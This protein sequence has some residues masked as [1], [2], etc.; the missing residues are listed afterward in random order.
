MKR[1]PWDWPFLAEPKELAGL[2][3]ALRLHL[4]LWGLPEMIDAAQVCVTELAANVIA[5]VGAG[6]PATLAVAMK[7][8]SLRIE[9]HDPDTRVL[10]VLLDAS[11]EAESGRGMVLVDA[12]AE[13]W[14]VDLRCDAKAV[15]C[16]LATELTTPHG[17]TETTQVA[18]ASAQLALYGAAN[19]VRS[20]GWSPRLRSRAVEASAVAL[21]SDLLHWLRAHGCDPDEA[22]DA[23]QTC[24]ESETE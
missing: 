7:G 3:R 22:L 4:S 11:G 15:W 24:F 1:Q 13:R 20:Q 23:A 14:G 2:R 21:I 5:H 16:E 10:P 18:R 9:M 8:T 17:H 12:L 6:T 19:N